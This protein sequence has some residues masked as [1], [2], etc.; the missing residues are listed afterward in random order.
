MIGFR[1]RSASTQLHFSS[2]V[3]GD[4]NGRKETPILDR[5]HGSGRIDLFEIS[6]QEVLQKKSLEM[7]LVPDMVQV[8]QIKPCRTQSLFENP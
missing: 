6:P 1:N 8:G 5:I 4:S 3:D 7:Q 2:I